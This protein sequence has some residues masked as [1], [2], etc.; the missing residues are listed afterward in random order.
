MN[1]LTG[2]VK[3]FDSK[4]GFGFIVDI[5]SSDSDE[6]FVHHSRLNTEQPCFKALYE[7]EYVEF[8]VV[9]ENEKKLADNVRGISGG[10]LMCESRR[11][12]RRQHDNG[13]GEGEGSHD[14]KEDDAV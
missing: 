6:Y 1:T 11:S 10:P 12:N 7:G 5:N 8:A 4:K 2:R 13:E 14:V 3:W 9:V